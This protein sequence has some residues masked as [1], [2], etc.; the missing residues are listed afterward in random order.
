MVSPMKVFDMLG[1]VSFVP[2][3][4]IFCAP[5]LSYNGSGAKELKYV[6]GGDQMFAGKFGCK[7]E[8]G[9]LQS[10]G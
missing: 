4:Q 9:L 6:V 5:V 1:L 2:P 8:G 10:A 3:C 7:T